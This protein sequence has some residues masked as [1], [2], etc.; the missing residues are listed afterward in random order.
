MPCSIDRLV[1]LHRES[2][3]TSRSRKSGGGWGETS[4]SSAARRAAIAGNS[5]QHCVGDRQAT[6]LRKWRQPEELT[7]RRG[8]CEQIEYM[9]ISYDDEGK[10]ARLSLRQEE[11]LADLQSDALKRKEG[12]PGKT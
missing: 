11:I 12:N 5:C 2:N 6:S 3:E 4:R 9:I 8:R 1:S 10:N 7:Q